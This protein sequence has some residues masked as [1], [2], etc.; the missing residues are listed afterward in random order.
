MVMYGNVGKKLLRIKFALVA[1]Q[2]A[3]FG[4]TDVVEDPVIES[5]AV[6][7]SLVRNFVHIVAKSSYS[8]RPSKSCLGTQRWPSCATKP[9]ISKIEER[10]I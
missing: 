5:S 6:A 10:R 7:I 8:S 3:D 9:F 2:R 4:L 1:G